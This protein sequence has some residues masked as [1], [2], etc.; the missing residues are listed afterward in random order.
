MQFGLYA[1]TPNVALGSQQIA[2]SITEALH[3]LP[4]GRRDAQFDHCSD[5]IKAAE[6]SGFQL[7]LF[8]ERHLGSDMT[9]WILASAVAPRL[10][11][12]RA[13]VAV[14]PGLWDPVLTA[15][16]AVS[17][18]R[19]CKGRM[20]L[21]IVNGWF[22]EEFKMFGGTVLQ[23]EERYRRTSEFI[24]ILRGLWAQDVFSYTGQHYSVEKARLL[25]KPATVTPPE[26]FSVSRSDRG[27]N[28]I[29]EYCDWWFIEL[30]TDAASTDDFLRSIEK[31][32]ADMTQRMNSAG[33]T[34]RFALNPFVGLGD[35]DE[36]ALAA[37][38]RQ[39]KAYNP[40]SDPRNVEE[41]MLPATRAGCI[42][43]PEKVHR[44]FRRLSDL[45]VELILCKLISTVENVKQIGKVLIEPLS[46]SAPLRLAR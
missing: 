30:P 32:V 45:G 9:A 40:N 11:T 15:K 29:A 17:L 5:V 42:G 27:L 14:H 7:C 23:G 21:N 35:T 8:A 46:G 31:S 24:D 38:V 41:R 1:P 12:M 19:L 37:I 16:L 3:P 34:V 44:Q 4:P 18:D 26:I 10:E 13:L 43:P 33:R 25:L 28:F 20:A 39:I 6:N 2:Q 22:D 36:G